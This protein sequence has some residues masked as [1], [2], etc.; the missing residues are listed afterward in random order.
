[1]EKKISRQAISIVWGGAISF[2]VAMG[3][4]RFAFTPLLPMMLHDH[5]IDLQGGTFLASIHYIGYLLGA[6]T[7]VLLP[8]LLSHYKIRIPSHSAIIR[9]SL[10][11]TVLLIF[12][13]ALPFPWLW[14]ACRF[15]TGISTAFAFVY[16]SGWSLERLAQ[17]QALSLSG[18]IYTGPG[19]GIVLSGMISILMIF[20]HFSSSAAWLG[21]SVIAAFMIA[22]VWKTFHGDLMKHSSITETRDLLIPVPEM[23]TL[24]SIFLIIAYGLAGF[25]Y[26]I[27]ATFLPVIAHEV[28]PKSAWIDYLWPIFGVSVVI[29]ALITKKIPHGADRR[30]VLFFIYIMQL[31]GVLMPLGFPSQGGF[32][33]G[34]ILVGFPFN[35]ISLLGMQ[36]A[37]R[38][39]PQESTTL[40]GLLSAMYGLGQIL[41]PSVASY[42]L[43]HSKSH[44]QA[45]S[46]S[47]MTAAA[48][49]GVGAFFFLL[50]RCLFPIKAIVSHD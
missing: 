27:T 19:I 10:L 31:T 43:S 1:M 50:M 46:F 21:F 15:L 14:P 8:W 7:C 34:I 17:L 24:E 26:I 42:F 32:L 18:L 40:M 39:R 12:G 3:F 48:S 28:I 44:A 49:L 37:R 2:V 38:L 36:E 35:I 22:A 11:V 23:W 45:F 41:G 33:L 29:G 47:L 30:S 13:M 6:S 25:G 20:F 4:A 5:V 9:Y 16:T